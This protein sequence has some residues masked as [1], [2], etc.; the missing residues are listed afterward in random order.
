MDS[1]SPLPNVTV[2]L[3]D[4]LTIQK[5]A[6]QT[7]ISQV[8]NSIM[9][10]IGSIDWLKL[11][12]AYFLRKDTDDRSRGKVSSDKGIEVGKFVSGTSG[13]MIYLDKLTNKTVAEVDKIYVRLK[14]YFEQLEIINE[15]SIGGKQIISPAGS[16]RCKSVETKDDIDYYRCYILTEQDGDKIENRFKVGD[17]ASCQ[18]FN[19]KEGVENNISNRYYWRLV[20]GIGEDYIDLSKSDC[21]TDSDEPA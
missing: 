1:S 16:I 14:A 8:E 4:T 18:M 11:G 6:L 13:A 10:N 19:A 17:Q 20:V 7:A 12:L 3:S 9:K 5:N 2:E 21:D 15:N